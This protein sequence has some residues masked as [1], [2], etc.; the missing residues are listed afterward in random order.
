MLFLM[1][2]KFQITQ[3]LPLGNCET[4]DIHG[5]NR[6]LQ[7]P[8]DTID[9]RRCLTVSIKKIAEKAGVSPATVSR[10]L[11]NPS[12]KCSSK[13][14]QDKIW[15]IA[16]E[17]NYVPNEAARNLK[18]GLS[19][20][21][22]KAYYINILMTRMDNSQ[23]DPFY[24]EL[25]RVIESE[26][27]AQICILSNVWYMS[28]FSNDKKCKTVDL[29]S[30]ID[31]LYREAEEKCDGLIIIGKCN[32]VALEKLNR[33]FK[34]VVLMNRNPSNYS[35]DEVVCDGRKVA[36]LAVEYLLGLNHEKIGYVGEC[37]NEARYRGFV[38]VLQK[39]DIDLVPDYVIKTK[40][41]E[42]EGFEAMKKILE[43]EDRPTGIYCANDITAI[44]MLKCLN[45]YK[46]RYYMP[47]IIACDDIEAA[48]NCKP[49]LTTIGLP[50]EEMGRFAVYL[51]LD[52]IRGKHK[53]C[54]RM[55]VEGRLIV[56][57]SCMPAQDS[58]WSD[59]VI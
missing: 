18:R 15:R 24:S 43:L 27:H 47:S 8:K 57:N 44:G 29:D 14:M 41:T 16:M 42:V 45:K 28:L 11:N 54:V 49:M 32:Q 20:Q 17:M 10:V 2:N 55:E 52:R 53:E 51:L 7:M 19:P 33:K 37:Q 4:L 9:E 59:Y 35:I 1:Y 23:A 13:E 25:L 38:E 40:Q 36:A 31:R 48:Q 22:D 26:I 6:V 30:V 21:K 56:R 58:V 5:V 3:R 12:Y 39:H 46:N 50:K 34:N